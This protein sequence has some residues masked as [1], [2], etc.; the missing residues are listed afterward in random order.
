MISEETETNDLLLRLRKSKQICKE[1]LIKTQ[2]ILSSFITYGEVE[3]RVK[4]T[5]KSNEEGLEVI[6][7]IR[8]RERR[9]VEGCV[10]F[11]TNY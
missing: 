1:R 2:L 5:F 3:D 7:K 11:L 6:R 10:C 4:L 8:E 9:S